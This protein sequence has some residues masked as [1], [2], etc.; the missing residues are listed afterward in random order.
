ML[1]A[2]AA[3]VVTV[4]PVLGADATNP[5]TAAQLVQA[6]RQCEQWVGRVDSLWLKA[7]VTWT[8]TQEGVAH[9]RDLLARQFPGQV[10]DPNQYVD[11]QPVAHGRLEYAFDRHRVRFLHELD[12][13]WAYLTLWD[14]R[15]LVRYE[16][17]SCPDRKWIILEDRRGDAFD[18]C[19]APMSC[20]RSAPPGLW[21]CTEDADEALPTYGRPEE[22]VRTGRCT[23]RG[24]DCHVLEVSPRE[25]RGL[26]IGHGPGQMVGSQREY[27]FIGEVKGIIDQSFRWYVGAEDQRLRGLVCLSEGRPFVE[28]WLSQYKQVRGGLWF[29][30]VQGSEVYEKQDFCQPYVDC[31]CDLKVTD[32]RIDEPLPDSLFHVDLPSNA[33]VY[34]RRAGQSG[35]K[36][37]LGLVGK[38]LPPLDPLGLTAFGSQ[39]EGKGVLVCFFDM[40]QRPSRNCLLQLAKQA[41]ALKEKGVTVVAVQAS[42]VDE[43][44]LKDWVKQNAVTFPVGMLGGDE[45]KTRLAWG[46]KALPWLILADKGHKVVAE[47]FAVSELE[48]RVVVGS[49]ETTH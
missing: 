21:W 23:Y 16:R 22:F 14:G 2:L 34:D 26:M 49:N 44:T 6:V 40:Q 41:V 37:A 31:R 46:V 27:G 9:R 30:M 47:G 43:A 4:Y 15:Q 45:E 7:D 20:L 48:E 3:I 19:L 24:T 25:V 33:R 35:A 42:R 5:P 38:T 12:G 29:P 11:L 17:Q 28:Y 10:L 36:A 8:K 1:T 32:L 18:N 39:T 13:Y